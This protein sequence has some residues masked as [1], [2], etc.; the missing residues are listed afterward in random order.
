MATSTSDTA[1]LTLTKSIPWRGEREHWSNGYHL[2]I[3]PSSDADWSALMSY[4]WNLESAFLA[5]DVQFETATGHL[6]GTPP[7]LVW[8]YDAGTVGEGG[9]PGT[10]VPAANEVAQTGDV[11]GWVRWRTDRKTNR[12]KPIY[13]RNYYHGIHTSG[14][15]DAIASTQHNFMLLL[16]SAWQTGIPANGKTFHRSGPKGGAP[17]DHTASIYCTTRTL[18]RRGKRKKP[19]DVQIMGSPLGE[20]FKWFVGKGAI[21]L[22]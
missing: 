9:T 12:G 21:E 2:D 6:P 22:P 5:A 8:E 18:E 16:G 17:Q 4:A 15:P 10:Y 20:F 19:M 3:A 11:A 1:F 13:L 7:V 14:S